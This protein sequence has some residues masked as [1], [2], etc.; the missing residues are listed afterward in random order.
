MQ[1]DIADASNEV[2]RKYLD[3]NPKEERIDA[4]VAAVMRAADR[5]K[6]TSLRGQFG[7]HLAVAN[8]KLGD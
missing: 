7:K 8:P 3:E 2:A 1:Q 5:S 6:I 4:G